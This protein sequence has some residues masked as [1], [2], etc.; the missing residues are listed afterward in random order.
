MENRGKIYRNKK[1]K[2]FTEKKENSDYLKKYQTKNFHGLTYNFFI[3]N[4]TDTFERLLKTF[5]FTFKGELRSKIC[6]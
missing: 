2:I 6:Y 4:K 1:T 5:I 3:E